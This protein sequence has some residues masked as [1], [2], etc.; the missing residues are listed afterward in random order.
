MLII[1]DIKD[2]A[3]D[4]L[5]CTFFFISRETRENRDYQDLQHTSVMEALLFKVILHPLPHSKTQYN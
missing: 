2:D 1:L 5:I 4:Q 3:D